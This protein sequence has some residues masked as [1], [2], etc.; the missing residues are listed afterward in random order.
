M[1]RGKMDAIDYITQCV[2]AGLITRDDLMHAFGRRSRMS[3]IMNRK[4]KMTLEQVRRL[5][6]DCGLDASILLRELVSK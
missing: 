5:H 2:V 1:S 3:E 6:F 4:R